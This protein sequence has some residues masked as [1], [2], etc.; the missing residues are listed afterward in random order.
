MTVKT[1]DYETI[2][3]SKAT[4]NAISILFKETAAQHRKMG[5]HEYAEMLQKA[6]EEIYNQLEKAGT[7][8]ALK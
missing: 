6:G 8:D 4:L 7:Y 2:T 5:A 3:A 1:T